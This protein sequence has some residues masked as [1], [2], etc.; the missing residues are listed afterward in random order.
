MAILGKAAVCSARDELCPAVFL[1]Q[2][3][4]SIHLPIRVPLF[5][6]EPHGEDTALKSSGFR[7]IVLAT[8]QFF[9]SA[10]ESESTPNG[11]GSSTSVLAA[12]YVV[13]GGCV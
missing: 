13:R 11:Y 9:C 1:C 8:K 10:V 2:G 7:N 12:R 4:S 6:L 5:L 3:F